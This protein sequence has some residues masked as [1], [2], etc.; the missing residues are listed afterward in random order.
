LVVAFFVARIGVFE[1]MGLL[2]LSSWEHTPEWSITSKL[3]IS[4]HQQV[5]LLE[6]AQALLKINQA[7]VESD[8]SSPDASASDHRS[9]IASSSGD[10][11]PPQGEDTLLGEGIGSGRKR[12]S[13][14]S[15]L[16][17]QSYQSS[18]A[19]EGNNGRPYIVH[20]RQLSND[21][22]PTTSGT[23]V[24]SDDD[25]E[26]MSAAF[27]LL[28]CSYGTPRTGPI[29]I[30]QDV[31]PVPPL[32]AKYLGQSLDQLSGSTITGVPN[33]QSS[34][35]RGR[36]ADDVQMIDEEDDVHLHGSSRSDDE[37]EGMFGMEE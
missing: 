35:M 15:S 12:V 34:Y 29:F 16:Y 2:T 36:H 23:S 5:Q 11:P 26:E 30:T 9:D 22:R 6:A 1:G 27:N 3:L 4:K 20:S 10:S 25:R 13:S 31:P 37:E 19:S 28:S 18:I 32:P 24:T 21:N 33:S 7:A 14:N 17:S 8:V